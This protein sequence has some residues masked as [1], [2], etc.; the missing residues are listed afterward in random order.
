MASM[1]LER[2]ATIVTLP[3]TIPPMPAVARIL[4]RY[5]RSQ[6]EAFIAV[7]IDL[8]DVFDGDTDVELNGDEVDGTNAEDELPRDSSVGSGP[9]CIISDPD[10]AVDDE[11]CDTDEDREEDAYAVFPTYGV[12]QTQ[13]PQ[14]P[15]FESERALMRP[16]LERIRETRCDRIG[17]D[18]Y[19]FRGIEG[20]C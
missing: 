5:D 13:D 12:D 7:A 1:P 14:P 8:L 9:R 15:L 10:L 16:H 4:G 20:E 19:A 17:R 3:G 2:P 11:G 18:S 6:V